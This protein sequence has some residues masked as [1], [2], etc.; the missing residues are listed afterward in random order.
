VGAEQQSRA[1]VNGAGERAFYMTEERR[2]GGIASNGGAVHFDERTLHETPC[3][4][5]FVNASGQERLAR[6]SRTEE[7]DRRRRPHRDP[8]QPFDDLVE[9]SAP[10]WNAGLE[11]RALVEFIWDSEIAA[12]AP[13]R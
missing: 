7:Q 8:V 1:I 11:Q 6:S 5:Q 4:L 12:P 9:G 13:G 3:L 2:H 10:R